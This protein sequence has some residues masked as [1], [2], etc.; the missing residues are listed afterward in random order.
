VKS[1]TWILILITAAVI[2][3]V[4]WTRSSP[5]PETSKWEYMTYRVSVKYGPNEDEINKL[6]A[7]GW[8]LAAV[9]DGQALFVFKRKK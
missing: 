2:L 3:T 7:E 5:S 6:G 1:R 8:E 4:G 9:Y